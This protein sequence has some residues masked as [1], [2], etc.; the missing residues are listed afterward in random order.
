MSQS[1]MF[2]AICAFHPGWTFRTIDRYEM[3]NLSRF[4]SSLPI[5][6]NQASVLSAVLVADKSVREHG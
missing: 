3:E 4:R 1:T 2:A 6:L 5:V